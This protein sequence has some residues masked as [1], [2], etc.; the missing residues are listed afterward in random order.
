MSLARLHVVTNDDVSERPDFILNATSII[1]ACRE[2]VAIHVRLKRATA[3]RMLDVAERLVVTARDAGATV[4][5]NER[6]DVAIAAGAAGVHLG[7]GSIPVTAVKPQARGLAIGYSAHS[8]RE[9]EQAS[10]DGADFLFLGTIWASGSHPGGS[11][12]GL[13]LISEGTSVITR[14]VIA[15]GGVT[16]SRSQQALRAG[17]HGVAVISGVWNTKAPAAAAVEYLNAMRAIS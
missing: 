11:T 14:P 3:T 2:R 5:V 16:P 7:S 17:A 13:T 9:A 15:I 1:E 8:V 10:D 12:A 4:I 6:F